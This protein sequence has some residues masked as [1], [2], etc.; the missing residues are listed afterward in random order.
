MKL[1]ESYL[2]QPIDYDAYADRVSSIH[3]SIK[4]KKGPGADF[5]GW[6]RHP[7]TYNREEVEAIKQA[8]IY[9][10][11]HFDI[12]VVCGIGGSYL[13]SRAVIEA[14]K[15]LYSGDKLEIVYLGHTFRLPIP[16]KCCT[17]FRARDLPSTLSRNRARPPKLRSLSDCLNRY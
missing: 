5:L 17:T 15:G 8:A 1:N 16:H 7:G 14:I 11:E 12:L 13:G 3:R 2:R 9:I 6:E 10:R 4:T